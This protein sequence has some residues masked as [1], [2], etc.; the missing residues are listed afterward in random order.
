MLLLRIHPENPQERLLTQA[1]RELQN[2]GLLVYPTDTVYAL[3][4]DMASRKGVEHL[5]RLKGVDPAKHR[6]ACIVPDFATLG[7]YAAQLEGPTFRLLKQHLPGPF[8]FILPAG[9][10]VPKHFQGRRREF[11]VRMVEHPIVQALLRLHGRPLVTT[12]LKLDDDVLE[13]PTDPDEIAE[14]YNHSADVM[15]DG[16]YGGNVPSTVVD[17]TDGAANAVVIR[18]G[19]GVFNG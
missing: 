19:L 4:C 5:C 12:S 15:I 16:G 13:Y 9:S 8:T 17:L 2:D 18:D 1:V 6:F 3:G 11:G 10:K 7:E 14:V